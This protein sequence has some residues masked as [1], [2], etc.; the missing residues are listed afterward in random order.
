MS[1]GELE[2]QVESRLEALRQELRD[3]A[4]AERVAA[5]GRQVFERLRRDATV[6]D[7]IP[8]LVQRY[9]SQEL[10]S[11]QPPVAA[12]PASG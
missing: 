2:R 12:Q 11:G 10:A 1:S 7:F 3:P 4:V 9:T 5:V 8:L 6:N